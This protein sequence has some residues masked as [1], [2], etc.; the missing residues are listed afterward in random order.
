MPKFLTSSLDLP[1]GSLR[2]SN[3]PLSRSTPGRFWE[4]PVSRL[5]DLGEADDPLRLALVPF[6]DRNGDVDLLSSRTPAP[7]SAATKPPQGLPIWESKPGLGSP[8][9]HR[10]LSRGSGPG[11]AILEALLHQLVKGHDLVAACGIAERILLLAA[12]SLS[13]QLAVCAERA[14]PFAAEDSGPGLGLLGVSGAFVEQELDLFRVGHRVA[15][16]V[17]G[18]L[19]YRGS[20]SWGGRVR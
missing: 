5:E 10:R 13:A 15:E 3:N 1:R 4:Q 12:S 6:E 8:P 16:G 17:G 11:D 7:Y 19:P 2:S 14:D 20:I 18:L 9:C